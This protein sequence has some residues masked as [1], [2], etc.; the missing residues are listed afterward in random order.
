MG[1]YGSAL[2]VA[3]LGKNDFNLSFLNYDTGIHAVYSGIDWVYTYVEALY[4]YDYKIVYFW[5]LNNI[6]DES[7]DFF[8]FICM[9]YIITNLQPSTFLICFIRCLYYK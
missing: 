2:D 4:M 5:F 7:M 3:K 8:F 9:I 1:I 6:Y